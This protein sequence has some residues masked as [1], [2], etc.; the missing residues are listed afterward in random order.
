MVL[1]LLDMQL[2]RIVGAM[3]IFLTTIVLM[4]KVLLLENP[5]TPLYIRPTLT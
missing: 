2:L 3:R 1:N 5:K 4:R